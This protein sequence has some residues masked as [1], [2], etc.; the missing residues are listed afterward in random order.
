MSMGARQQPRKPAG[1]PVGGQFAPT[2]HDE[3]DISLL[4]RKGQVQPLKQIER[5]VWEV[6]NTATE[7]LEANGALRRTAIH[8]GGQP[9]RKAA[10]KLAS[11]LHEETWGR[12]VEDDLDALKGRKATV[13]LQDRTGAVT[14][15]EG[16]IVTLGEGLALLNKGST[17]KGIYLRGRPGVPRVLGAQAGYGRAEA[18]AA[19]FRKSEA[20][21]PELE[22][23]HFDDIPVCDG[24][25]EPPSAVV[26]AFVL[27]H[28]GFDGTQD[29]RGCVFFATDRDPEKVVN[30]YFVAPP[31]SGLESEHGSFYTK[32]LVRWGGRIKGFKP[33]SLSFRDA[34]ELGNKA[35]DGGMGP[36]WAAIG[37]AG[38]QEPSS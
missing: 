27:D 24:E 21:V 23:S 36:T 11:L 4:P 8:V 17:T 3:A 6:T 35:S 16:T 34:M 7:E 13:L 9:H 5:G 1:T 19:D 30:G 29:G 32:D 12:Y 26:A 31:G 38:K 10:A 25:S 15:R 14:A 18:L 33:G 28:P 22:P 20:A 37:V 2:A